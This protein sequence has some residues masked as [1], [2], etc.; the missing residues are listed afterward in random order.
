MRG[1]VQMDTNKKGSIKSFFNT[2]FN[3]EAKG[4]MS[5]SKSRGYS[6]QRNK[7][8]LERKRIEVQYDYIRSLVR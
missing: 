1:C 2:L 5:E 4:R 8:N 7:E 6:Y 3:R